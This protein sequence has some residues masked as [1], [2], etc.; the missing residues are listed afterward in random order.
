M[1]TILP[2][3]RN[4]WQVI[5]QALGQQISQNLPGAVERGYERGQIQQGLNQLKNL[6]P[7]QISGMAPHQ[8]LAS[9]LGPFAG[10]RQGA[11]YAEAILPALKDLMT[12]GQLFPEGA[13]PLRRGYGEYAPEVGQFEQTQQQ[14][15]PPV[16]YDAAAR[17][18]QAGEQAFKYVP[19]GQGKPQIEPEKTERPTL[20]P[21]YKTT[22]DMLEQAANS[23]DPFKVIDF[24]SKTNKLAREQRQ[25]LYNEYLRNFETEE[26][27]L[28]RENDFRNF[29]ENATNKKY[30]ADDFNR[31]VRYSEKYTSEPSQTRRLYHAER[32]LQKYNN[33]ITGLEKARKA[34]GIFENLFRG[35][36]QAEDVLTSAFKPLVEL[37][38]IDKA[39]ELASGLGLGPIQTER[40]INALPKASRAILSKIQ[41]APST[42]VPTNAPYSTGL[43]GKSGKLREKALSKLPDIIK[44]AI[45]AGGPMASIKLIRDELFQKNYLENEFANAFQEALNRGLKLSDY[46]KTEQSELGRKVRRPFMDIFF[47]DDN[48]PIKEQ[49]YRTLRGFK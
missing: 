12:K 30:K 48:I 6:T 18:A 29:A 33:A 13:G 43:A 47:S 7:D 27:R 44:N 28:K 11:Q 39:K 8:V 36:K 31:L 10:T 19:P 1:T 3:A 4:P 2:A 20:P 41:E 49:A 17:A 34:P 37:G 46:Q 14:Q 25:E 45:E 9:V 15:Q 40:V 21:G 23:S 22:Q 26:N 38:E 5:D 42:H 16:S 24:Y 35:Q 32:D